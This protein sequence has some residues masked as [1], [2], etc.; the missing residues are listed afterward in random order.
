MNKPN[1]FL[2][3]DTHFSHANIMKYCMRPFFR[4]EEMDEAILH[5]I[6]QMVGAGDTLYHLGDFSFDRYSKTNGAEKFRAQINC[7]NIILITGNH[8]PHYSTGQAKR[9]FASIFSGCYDRMRLRIDGYDHNGRQREI[10]LDHYALRV[11]NKSHHGAWHAYGH[12]HAS[13]PDCSNSLSTDVGVDAVATRATGKTRAEINK[14]MD[15]LINPRPVS[16]YDPLSYIDLSP[17]EQVKLS[18]DVGLKPENYRPMSLS[19]FAQIMSTK[20]FRPIDHHGE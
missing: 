8:D 17:R 12:S 20:I 4:V 1:I 14:A 7:R 3:A 6:N 15:I 13:L 11:W 9:E 18:L 19:E 10:V 16:G 5:N 2:T